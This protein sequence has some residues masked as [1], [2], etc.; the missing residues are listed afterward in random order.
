MAYVGRRFA[1]TLFTAP[2]DADDTSLAYLASTPVVYLG[3]YRT[4]RGPAV[5]HLF[6][7][8]AC[9]EPAVGDV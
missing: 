1:F 8:D 9:V 3:F 5:G 4:P 6:L 7:G 2:S